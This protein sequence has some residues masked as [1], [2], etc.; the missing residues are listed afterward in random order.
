MEEIKLDNLESIDIGSSVPEVS[1]D[2]DLNSAEFGGGIELLMNEKHKST[3]KK[4][5]SSPS[6]KNLE[7]DIAEI[8]NIGDSGLSPDINKEIKLDT[9][10]SFVNKPNIEIAKATSS[11]EMGNETWDGF[12]NISSINIEEEDKRSRKL[13]AQDLLKEKFEIL[14]KLDQLEA[15]GATLSKKYSMESDL[16]EM[17]G[18]YEHLI[19]EKEKSNSVKFQGKILTTMITGLEFLNNKFDPF[20]IKLDGWSEQIN[21]NIDDYDEIF[22]E[23]HEKYKSKAKMA[24][25]LKLLFQLASSGI[26]I[27]M[28]NTMFK[29]AL[30]GMDDIMRQ[31]P[32]LMNHFTKAAISSMETKTPGLSHFMND[33]GMSHGRDTNEIRSRPEQFDAP[34]RPPSRQEPQQAPRPPPMRQ[35]MKGPNN[36]DSLLSSL[37]GSE[38]KNVTLDKDSTIS[39]ED[40]DNLSISSAASNKRKSS[41]RKSNKSV[42]SLP[43]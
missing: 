26:M 4:S 37:G 15:K 23:L 12:K 5:D 8:N 42:M 43:I 20:D 7:N 25:E 28:T 27:H 41:K 36:I 17:K 1:L 10:D 14:R 29:S 3:T 13:S 11:M 34:Q 2:S 18:E 39:I 35:E 22:A 24:P 40:V 21:E 38:S 30:P 6:L 33:F 31:N 32:D 9:K 19:Q 16:A